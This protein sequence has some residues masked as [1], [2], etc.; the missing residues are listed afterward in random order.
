MP[1]FQLNLIFTHF[2][3]YWQTGAGK[4][5]LLKLLTG[6]LIPQEGIIRTHTH[7]KIARYHQHLHEQLDLE[8]SALEYMMKCFPEV[9]EVEEM[10]RIIGRFGLSGRQQVCPIKQLSDGQR[11]R[12]VFAW[13]AFQ[14]PHMLFLDGEL[15]EK[16]L[17]CDDNCVPNC[18]F[19]FLIIQIEP[20]NHLDL[21]TIE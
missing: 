16:C 21:D 7:L 10:R 18:D 17:Q 19:S 12:V 13:L 3:H 14:V 8:L 9:K 15:N 2:S 20:T 5:T 6:D 11:C 1:L 4:S